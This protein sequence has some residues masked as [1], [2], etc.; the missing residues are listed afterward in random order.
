[1]ADRVLVDLGE[2][3]RSDYYSGFMFKVYQQ[4]VGGELGGGGRYDR[5]FDRFG[6]DVPAVGFGFDLARLAE[7][8]MRNDY[9]N[10]QPIRVKDSEGAEGLKHLLTLRKQG[11]VVDLGGA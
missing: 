11:K 10:G 1:V 2:V 7:A 4:G 9:A 5:L 6:M 3:R 8:T